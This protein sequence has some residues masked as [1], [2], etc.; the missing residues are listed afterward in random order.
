[1][2]VST[3]WRH[4]IFQSPGQYEA[5]ATLRDA[6]IK[7]YDIVGS[8]SFKCNYLKRLN[9]SIKRRN[10]TFEYKHIELS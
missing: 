10:N 8:P 5:C 3:S 1:M 6:Q 7:E 4:S 9:K 2:S